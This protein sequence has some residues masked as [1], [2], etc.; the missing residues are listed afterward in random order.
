MGEET[1]LNFRRFKRHFAGL[2]GYSQGHPVV[3]TGDSYLVRV[4]VKNSGRTRAEKVQYTRR[5][6]PSVDSTEK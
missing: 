1:I 2:S 5:S 4:T 6:S 3:W